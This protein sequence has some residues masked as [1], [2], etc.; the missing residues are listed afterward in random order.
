MLNQPTMG[1]VIWVCIHF[2]S[3]TIF[4]ISW[5]DVK[6]LPMRILCC[7][8]CMASVW[9]T[10]NDFL[11]CKLFIGIRLVPNN[12]QK[13]VCGSDIMHAY[14]FILCWI[15]AIYYYYYT[16]ILIKWRVTNASQLWSDD[17]FRRPVESCFGLVKAWHGKLKWWQF[18]K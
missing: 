10:R 9:S 17:S 8:D 3:L 6:T 7:L 2:T 18:S 5:N 14:T 15:N 16:Y 4:L 1:L 12:T 13:M 11:A